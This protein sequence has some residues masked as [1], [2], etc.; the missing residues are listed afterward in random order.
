MSIVKTSNCKTVVLDLY[1]HFKVINFLM[2]FSWFFILDLFIMNN[3]IIVLF[4]IIFI[5]QAV[6]LTCTTGPWSS[7]PTW[8]TGSSETI[9]INF[10]WKANTSATCWGALDNGIICTP[11]F[12]LSFPSFSFTDSHQIPFIIS[13]KNTQTERDLKKS[14]T[15]CFQIFNLFSHNSDSFDRLSSVSNQSVQF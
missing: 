2:L 6:G 5:F 9:P 7:G 3:C 13:L 15:L 14:H 11:T 12:W 4:I 10:R 1:V 8:W